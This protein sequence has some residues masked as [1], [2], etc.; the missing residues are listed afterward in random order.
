MTPGLT[1]LGWIFMLVSTFSVATLTFYCFKR[2][3]TAPAEPAE[4]VQHF[5]SA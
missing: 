4:E 5:R 2:V 3:L 1:T